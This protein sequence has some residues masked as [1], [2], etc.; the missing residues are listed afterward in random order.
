MIT[1][2]TLTRS[3]SLNGRSYTLRA[4]VCSIG[5]LLY[6]MLSEG[7]AEEDHDVLW[8]LLSSLEMDGIDGHVLLWNAYIQD[9]ERISKFLLG[10]IT[11][12]FSPVQLQEES[13]EKSE[14]KIHWN[15]LLADYC[16]TFKADPFTVWHN[17][18]LPFFLQMVAELPGIKSMSKLD[19]ALAVGAG[20]GGGDNAKEW[21]ET[22]KKYRQTGGKGEAKRELPN[23]SDDDIAKE[24]EAAKREMLK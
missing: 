6:D 5:A 2:T 12:G 10:L 13:K 21:Q 22:A 19:T 7:V 15:V 1:K 8:E 23:V 20:F 9:K 24:R 14:N 11:E 18:P 16:N 4:P 17:T 3:V